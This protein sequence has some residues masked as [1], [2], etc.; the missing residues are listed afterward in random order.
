[1]TNSIAVTSGRPNP[2]VA[3]LAAARINA[4]LH[5]SRIVP[6]HNSRVSAHSDAPSARQV[7]VMEWPL[8]AAT[9][10]HAIHTDAETEGARRSWTAMHA[11]K[12]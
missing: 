7:W 12:E 4:A 2:M 9:A 3:T 11:A 8:A 10:M 5:A 6:N 1:M